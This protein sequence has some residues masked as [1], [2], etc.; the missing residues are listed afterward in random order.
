MTTLITGARGKVGQAVIARLHAA[1]LP[2]RA[3]SADPAELTVPSGVEIAEL[4]LDAPETFDAALEGVRQVFLY[5][6]P[7]GIDAFL[8]AAESAGVEHIV[9]LSSASVLAPDAANDP[10]GKHNLAVE[11]ALLASGLPTTLLRAGAFASNALGWSWPIGNNQPI[12]HAFPDAGIALIHPLDI[13]DIAVAALTGTELRGRALALTGPQ[14]LTFRE[15]L[16]IVS[17]AIGREVPLVTITRDEAAADMAQYMSPDYA[18]S[19][20]SFWAAADAQPETI[21]DTT[22]SLLGTPARTFAQWAGE[23]ATAFSRN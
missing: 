22:E 21:C 9:L 12:R 4:R 8:T 2:V 18:G 11:Q 20:L 10:M 16:A 13:A 7:E 5:P 3:A 6:N 15:Q 23:N 17:T 1:H 14:T 19:L